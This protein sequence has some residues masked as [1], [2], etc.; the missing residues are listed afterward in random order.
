[1]NRLNIDAHNTDGLLK[2]RADATFMS[3]AACHLHKNPKTALDF[4]S[5]HV[6]QFV[7]AFYYTFGLLAIK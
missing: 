6:K 1:M 5:F 3:A 7:K 4:N 2:I